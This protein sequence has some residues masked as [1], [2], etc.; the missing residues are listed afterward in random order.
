MSG[1]GG[2]RGVVA[3]TLS[4]VTPTTIAAGSGAFLLTARGTNYVA[5]TAVQWNGVALPTTVTSQTQLTAQV[6][7]AQVASPGTVTIRIAKPDSTTSEAMTLTISGGDSSEIFSLTSIAPS[8]VAAGSASFTITATG[9][10]F[11][12]GAAITLNGTPVSTVFESSTQLRA[13]VDA[14]S[15]ATPGSIAVGVINGDHSASS[16]LPLTVTGST[17]GPPPA[18][19]S[20][21]PN[22][23]PSGVAAPLTLTAM[24]K[25]F[26]QGSQVMWNGLPMKTSFVSSAQLVASIPTNFFATSAI[27]TSTVFVLN[28]DSTVSGEL[29]FSITISPS[30]TPVLTS[31]S[32]GKSNVGDSGLSMTLNGSL[33]AAGATAWFNQLAL[34]TTVVSSTQAVAQI[35]SSALTAVTEAQI[36]IQ[37]SQSKLSNP[38][39]YLVGMSVFF[40]QVN[41]AVWDGPRNI[42]Y[43]TQPSA[44]PS[45]VVKNPDTVL[46]IDPV[47]L[48]V[49]WI[50]QFTAGSYPD[51]LALSNDG[52]YLYVSLDGAGTVQ[53]LILG[54]PAGPTRGVTIPLGSDPTYGPYW[55]MDLQVSPVNSGTIAVARGVSPLNSSI[56]ALGGVALFDGMTQRPDS[57]GWTEQHPWLLDTLQ[58]SGDGETIYAAN[59]ENASGDFY[60]LEVEDSG[61]SLKSATAGVFTNP[62]LYIHYDAQSGKVYGDDGVVVDPS[63]PLPAS[64]FQSSG[65]MVPVSADGAAYFVAQPS[66]D[67]GTVSYLVQSFGITSLSATK[68]LPL[69]LVSGIPQ[70][71][72]RWHQQL[73]SKPAVDGLVFTTRREVNCIYS[74]CSVGDGRMYVIALPF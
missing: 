16:T 73:I 74:P 63:H 61:V 18:L 39:P 49:Q 65:V 67:F 38:I 52:K 50:Y 51:R 19:I 11:V 46:A 14:A 20:I 12:N 57:V 64:S 68:Q 53:Q 34:P 7:A 3:P 5:G 32:P 44:N 58:W 70:H 15:I 6:S 66:S 43:I 71:I 41:D 22:T 60:E 47:T 21:S 42:L 1:C 45:S 24:G 9:A 48:A 36:T 37:N 27:G 55:A 31:I 40:S 62:N 2:F 8:S 59:N 4:G 29:P 28:P 17:I 33:F 35:P 69:Y 54:N 72:I 13:A 10:G 26:V 23:S 25:N 30:T 56:L